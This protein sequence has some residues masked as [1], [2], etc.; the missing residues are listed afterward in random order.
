[1]HEGAGDEDESLLSDEDDDEV[2]G[3]LGISSFGS[4][5][6]LVAVSSSCVACVG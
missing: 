6:S 1:V 3:V 5:L 4:V 2:F